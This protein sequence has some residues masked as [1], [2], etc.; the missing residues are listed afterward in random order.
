L[1]FSALELPVTAAELK[2]NR[3]DV[4]YRDYCS[5]LLIPLNKCRQSTLYMPWK[6]EDERHAYEKCEYIE[7]V[8]CKG[9]AG[10]LHR[11]GALQFSAVCLVHVTL[12]NT[13]LSLFVFVCVHFQAFEA[14]GKE[15]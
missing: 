6:C 11:F 15:V 14:E 9:Q 8:S 12:F 3:I 7:Y 5:H 1:R 2:A 13:R 4:A 10:L